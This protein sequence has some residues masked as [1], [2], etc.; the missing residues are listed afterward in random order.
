MAM[1]RANGRPRLQARDRLFWMALRRIWTNWRTAL[2]LVRPETVV[3]WHRTWLR[4]QWSRRSTLRA[5]G[6]S[7]VTR[8]IR[9]LVREIATANPLRGAP[10]I[11]GEWRTLGVDV[12]E[13]TVS[14]LLGTVTRPPSQTWRTFLTN[15]LASAAS[16]DFF[17]VPTLMGRVLFVVVVLSHHRRR[18]LHL[19]TTAHPTAELAAQQVV[20]AFPDDTA[21]RCLHRDRDRIYGAAFQRRVAGMGIAE[22]VSAPASPWQN[23]FVERVIGS[24]RRECLDHVIVLNETHLQRVLRSY[25]SYYHRTRTHLRLDKD[26]PDRRPVCETSVGPIVA[27]PEE[28]GLHHRYERRAA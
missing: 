11:H 24:I 17:T 8:E 2:V 16:M 21:P 28:G 20:E 7:P 26:T 23:P 18:I 6:R 9:A 19:N 14:R 25:L 4:R 22:V 13:R 27:M 3:G 12:S 15:H 10:R 5:R 1:K